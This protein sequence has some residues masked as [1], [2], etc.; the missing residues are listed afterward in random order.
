MI[1]SWVARS[2]ELPLHVELDLSHPASYPALEALIPHS[3]RWKHVGF[4]LELGSHL[5]LVR[6]RNRLHSLKRLNLTFGDTTGTVDFCEIAPQLTEIWLR[7]ICKPVVIKLPW[8][9]LRICTLEY[10]EVA[11]YVLQHAKSLRGLHLDMSNMPEYGPPRLEMP[12]GPHSLHPNL[13]ALIVKWNFKD[14]NMNLFLSSITLPSLLSL[15]IHFDYPDI[16][17]EN[18]L[19]KCLEFSPSRLVSLDIEFDSRWGTIDRELL[20]GLNL[21]HSRH[22]LPRLRSLAFRGEANMFIEGL[23]D[24]VAIL[25]N[26][27]LECIFLQIFDESGPPQFHRFVS[28]GLNI[29]YGKGWGI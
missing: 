27:T 20:D 3:H 15:K 26:L 4:H 13:R 5:I 17:D 18:T 25:E 19:I 16:H 7:A 2:K 14:S 12:I 1:H 11:H 29:K 22:I 9:Q 8:E 24:G 28:E 23:R 21:N 6:V 10:T